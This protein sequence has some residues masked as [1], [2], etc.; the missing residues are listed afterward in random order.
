LARDLCPFAEA[1]LLLLEDFF[2]AD[3]LEDV[4]FFLLVDV[5]ELLCVVA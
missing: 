1:D 3:D 5:A 2:E 4:D